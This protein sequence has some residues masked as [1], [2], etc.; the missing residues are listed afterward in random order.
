MHPWKKTRAAAIALVA[1][2]G[3]A[4]AEISSLAENPQALARLKEC[5][6][7]VAV[8]YSVPEPLIWSVMKV[9]NGCDQPPPR[10][11]N[12]SYDHGCMQINSVWIPDL[13]KKTGL[14][15][16]TVRDR[17]L[18]DPCWNAGI[19]AYVL[20]DCIRRKGGDVW[21]GV[22]CYNPG[23]ATSYIRDVARA[24]VS[25]YGNGIFGRPTN[26]ASRSE[27]Q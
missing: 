2:A 20:S 24:A 21:K 16:E 3:P 22:G 8:R 15:Q 13:S 14:T 11:R 25:L 5:V 17:L 23:R 10:N 9:E 18:N 6:P 12:G 26:A 19:G 7:W 1:L 4:S 27:N